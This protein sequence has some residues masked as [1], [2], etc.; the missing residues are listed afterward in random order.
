MMTELVRQD[1]LDLVVAVAGEQGVCDDD[2]TGGTHAHQGGIRLL[3]FLRQVPLINAAH[4]R[5]R[6]LA[7]P[8]Q[9][10]AEN[11]VL[12]RLELVEDGEEHHRGEPCQ[13]KREADEHGPGYNPP[14]RRSDTNDGVD[15]FDKDRAQHQADQPSLGFVQQPRAQLLVREVILVLQAEAV[16]IQRRADELK[17]QREHQHIQKHREEVILARADVSPVAQLGGPAGS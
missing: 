6:A 1:G 13:Q 11:I 10:I 17:Q 7:K 4:P 2:A 15:D 3:G 12:Q 5:S 9:P 8:G 16:V 14:A